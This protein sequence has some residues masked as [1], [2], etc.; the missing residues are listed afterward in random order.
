MSDIQLV[1]QSR[2]CVI[3]SLVRNVRDNVSHPPLHSL[4]VST[5]GTC[6]IVVALI[7]LKEILGI[8]YEAFNM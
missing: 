5:Y 2:P 1:E 7:P 6:G 4:P 8:I 3:F